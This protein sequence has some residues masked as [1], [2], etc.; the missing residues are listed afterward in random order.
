MSSTVFSAVKNEAPFLLEWVAYHRV[1]GFD[2]VIIVSNDCTD[3]TVALLDALAAAGEVVHLPQTVPEG[4][5]PQ[6]AATA[7]VNGAGLVKDGD[8]CIFLDSDEFLNIHAGEGRVADLVERIGDYQAM[9][10]NWRR[11]G[12]SG[13]ASF[14][15][16]YVSEAFTRAET[17]FPEQTLVK[18]FFRKSERVAGFSPFLHRCAL[19][20]RKVRLSEIINSAGNELHTALK[21]RGRQNHRAW[22]K[23]GEHGWG[24]VWKDE[25]GYD[26][27]QINHYM[28]RDPA[29]FAL[30]ILRGRGHVEA[31]AENLRHTAEF[32]QK[33]NLNEAED[34][35][36]LRWSGR[37]G[38]KIAALRRDPAVAAAALRA[39]QDYVAAVARLGQPAG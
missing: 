15:G 26:I 10:I 35:T 39:E 38:E 33:N 23:E 3:H 9:L 27:A 18:T 29:S 12:D 37:V 2:Q 19:V 32:Y 5:S 20:P 34:C 25:M 28:V 21:P 36:I 8:W 14:P 24:R 1:I 13:N 17:P 11:F 16:R 6:A 4:A 31:G 22:V 30:K 7:L